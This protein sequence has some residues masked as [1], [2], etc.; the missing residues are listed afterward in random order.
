MLA[1][2]LRVVAVA[3]ERHGHR[4]AP[5][6]VRRAEGPPRDLLRAVRGRDDDDVDEVPPEPRPQVRVVLEGRHR[7]H[8][9]RHG[10]AAV[11]GLDAQAHDEGLEIVLAEV[12]TRRAREDD[13]LRPRP[14][15]EAPLCD[16]VR[17]GRRPRDRRPRRRGGAADGRPRRP[18]G[19]LGRPVVLRPRA[20][21]P[22]RQR[23]LDIERPIRDG[24]R[25]DQHR[26]DAPLERDEALVDGADRV[27]R[28]LD[29]LAQGHAVEQEH[30]RVRHDHQHHGPERRAHET[31][32][33]APAPHGSSP[34]G[35]ARACRG[36]PLI[37]KAA[38]AC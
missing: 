15:G 18:A 26:V 37:G 25:V 10:V 33:V 16:G 30:H 24:D 11:A 27:A 1:E 14:R 12:P 13:L 20:L 28:A 17:R 29:R 3:H 8:D 2:V 32:G 4:V 21:R 6:R 9:E 7:V 19:R 35:C 5:D 34:S 23:P 38:S 22:R 36:W 31:H